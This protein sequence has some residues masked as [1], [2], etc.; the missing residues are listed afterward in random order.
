MCSNNRYHFMT[1]S[2]GRHS[3]CTMYYVHVVLASRP[4]IKSFL[5]PK[6][7]IKSQPYLGP[8]GTRHGG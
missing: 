4:T 1:V 7:K 6:F 2:D 5:V 3:Q 8:Y